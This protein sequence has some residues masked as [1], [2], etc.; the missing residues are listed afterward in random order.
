MSTTT[1]RPALDLAPEAPA[2]SGLAL[3]LAL[4]AIP[5]VTVAWELVTL[6]G[7]VFGLP[8]TLAA[9]ATGRQARARRLGNEPRRMATTAVV[10]AG[11]ALVALVLNVGAELIATL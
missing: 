7:I 5:G 10:I 1:A 6:G 11:L 8:L 9:I 2:R 4:L 3:A